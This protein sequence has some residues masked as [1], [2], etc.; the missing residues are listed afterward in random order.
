VLRHRRP[1]SLPFPNAY[2]H[3]LPRFSFSGA[4]G[5]ITV[6]FSHDPDY[7]APSAAPSQLWK[8]KTYLLSSIPLRRPRTILDDAS[9]L[10]SSAFASPL[11][12]FS[13]RPAQTTL[14]EVYD[15]DID[16]HENEVIE[17]ERGEETEL[18]DSSE[19]ARQVKVIF[20]MN[21]ELDDKELSEKAK[22]RRRWEILPLRTTS[23][24]TGG[25]LQK[26]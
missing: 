22:N 6:S 19:I 5:E 12:L 9:E 11:A 1:I 8:S 18:D 25:I 3:I 15:A 14:E 2:S 7:P 10:I 24:R 21:K 16:L 20:T 23:R 17:T 13:G 26:A 4:S